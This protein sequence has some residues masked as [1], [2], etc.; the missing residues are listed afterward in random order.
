MGFISIY[1]FALLVCANTTTTAPKKP[2]LITDP[3]CREVYFNDH[4]KE[5][6]LSR[7]D[8]RERCFGKCKDRLNQRWDALTRRRQMTK[9]QNKKPMTNK[10]NKKPQ[11]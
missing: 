2:C 1:F 9:K 5:E 11:H 8:I 10:Q 6:C 3:K 7:E 4:C